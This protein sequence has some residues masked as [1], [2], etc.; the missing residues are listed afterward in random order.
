VGR[1]EGFDLGDTFARAR[2]SVAGTGQSSL[3][4]APIVCMMEPRAST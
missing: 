4:L 1:E 2:D 3:L